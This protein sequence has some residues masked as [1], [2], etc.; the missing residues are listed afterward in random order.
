MAKK[1][2]HVLDYDKKLFDEIRERLKKENPPITI[3]EKGKFLTFNDLPHSQQ[4][5]IVKEYYVY[6]YG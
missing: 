6:M 2:Q 1:F 5:K 3:K 4:S